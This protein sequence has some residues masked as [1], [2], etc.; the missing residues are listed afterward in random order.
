MARYAVSLSI[1]EQLLASVDLR[2]TTLITH[3]A[4]LARDADRTDADI[5]DRAQMLRAEIRTAGVTYT[6]LALDLP[7]AFHHAVRD[8]QDQVAMTIARLEENTRGDFAYYSDI[9]LHGRPRSP[10]GIRRPLDRQRASHPPALARPGRGTP[11]S[12][13]H[14]AGHGVD[15]RCVCSVRETRARDRLGAGHQGAA[16][17]PRGMPSRPSSAVRRRVL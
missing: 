5:D 13:R 2:A 16:T 10:S 11:P 3:I 8:D 17:N 14:D 1:L 4:A 12:P 15:L 9:A 7:L 6:E